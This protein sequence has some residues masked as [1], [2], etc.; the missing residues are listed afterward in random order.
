MAKQ[1]FLANLSQKD[2][3]CVEKC[4]SKAHKRAFYIRIIQ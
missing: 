2:I 4:D 1:E 3:I